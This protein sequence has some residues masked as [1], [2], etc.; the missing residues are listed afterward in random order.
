MAET[1]KGTCD[2]H[3]VYYSA[4]TIDDVP[5]VV[6]IPLLCHTIDRPSFDKVTDSTDEVVLKKCS[7]L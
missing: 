6:V 1:P 7:G 5:K 4:I 3:E 2:K